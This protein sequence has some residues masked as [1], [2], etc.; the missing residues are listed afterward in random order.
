MAKSVTP[1]ETPHYTVSFSGTC[2]VKNE[3]GV[4]STVKAFRPITLKFDSLDPFKEIKR[5]ETGYDHDKNQPII[6]E[7]H[8]VNI[9][10]VM[11]REFG[12]RALARIPGFIR[13]RTIGIDAVEAHNGAPWHEIPPK[14][15]SRRL[16]EQYIDKNDIPLDPDNVPDTQRLRSLVVCFL[17][18][19]A[20]F[21]RRLKELKV[22]LSHEDA[23]K[24]LNADMP[25]PVLED[26]P[27]PTG[28]SRVAATAKGQTNGS[29]TQT[30]LI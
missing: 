28:V 8:I 5:F 1:K 26:V 23:Y 14:F 21:F 13:I 2:I 6:Q 11:K 9:Q 4:G 24:D 19:P 10:G 30:D 17:E 18:D 29:Q 25:A 27:L 3:S 20:V 22:R 16:L 12:H 7:T 15:L